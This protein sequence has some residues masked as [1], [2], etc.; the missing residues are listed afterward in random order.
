MPDRQ[1]KCDWHIYGPTTEAMCPCPHGYGGP[2]EVDEE[3]LRRAEA[4]LVDRA[5]PGYSIRYTKPVIAPSVITRSDAAFH[6][7]SMPRWA[8]RYHLIIEKN[9]SGET[10]A[11]LVNVRRL[12]SL[13]KSLRARISAE[14]AEKITKDTPTIA[15]AL[16]RFPPDKYEEW[17]ASDGEFRLIE[18]DVATEYGALRFPHAVPYVQP[19]E[20]AGGVCAHGAIFM[21]TVLL[22]RLGV[23]VLGLADIAAKLRKHQVW[24]GLTP[25]EVLDYFRHKVGRLNAFHEW[26]RL[27]APRFMR[28][29]TTALCGYL[30][31]GFPAII[32]VDAAKLGVLDEEQINELRKVG[33]HPESK[34][35][36]HVVLAIGFHRNPRE[37]WNPTVLFQDTLSGPFGEISLKQLVDA[38]LAPLEF[39]FVVPVPKQVGLALKGSFELL[40]P[41]APQPRLGVPALLD[42]V[43]GILRLHPADD[44]RFPR[45]GVGGVA[46]EDCT[47]SLIS[48]RDFIERYVSCNDGDQ[49]IGWCA[50]GG[51]QGDLP[52]WLWAQ[53]WWD[54]G[55]LRGVWGWDATR[56]DKDK[57]AEPVPAQPAITLGCTDNGTE[58]IQV[59]LGGHDVG[60]PNP[61]V[62]RQGKSLATTAHPMARVSLISSYAPTHPLDSILPACTRHA[63]RAVDL[64]CFTHW[65]L[66]TL[67]KLLYPRDTGDVMSVEA[68]VERWLRDNACAKVAQMISQIVPRSNGFPV[69]A[70]PAL[71][72]YLPGITHE[73]N[74]LRDT[75]IN[76]LKGL[77]RIG[78]EL[79]KELGEAGPVVLEIVAGNVVR[80]KRYRSG[81][82]GAKRTTLV[83]HSEL[84]K[85]QLL[86]KSLLNVADLARQAG[87]TVAIE[88]EPGALGVLRKKESIDPLVCALNAEGEALSF[89]GLNLDIG[90][91][92]LAEIGPNHVLEDER[93]LGRVCHAH[94]SDFGAGHLADLCPLTVQGRKVFEQWLAVLQEAAAI[95]DDYRKAN[96]LPPW[97]G[98]V[99]VEVEA[100]RSP[101]QAFAAYHRT[102]SL[103]RQYG[104]SC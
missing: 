69:L 39:D 75:S 13:R 81:S 86:I 44:S 90:H 102:E 65:Q 19:H 15:E 97:S 50:V 6:D 63:V 11:G 55:S 30:R 58:S 91:Y 92:C 17:A 29:V 103:I 1:L 78:G 66:L 68:E 28:D 9:G 67:H 46:L 18:A 48:A 51:L 73:Q 34:V 42:R 5:Y 54:E 70:I 53:E 45:F 31:S 100:C 23:A 71:A 52:N 47:Y 82:S 21:T 3:S 85:R 24:L 104:Y 99:A 35:L 16:L 10:Y 26:F 25:P 96:N 7:V 4:L 80:G 83:R 64:Y 72:S 40:N 95:P 8:Y 98:Y 41:P 32:Y 43:L 94:I 88:L 89:V 22:R 12:L 101:E 60:Y 76:G 49:R 36:A 33:P 57:D 74:N 14:D 56:K 77:L 38:R 27:P 62:M 93:I 87:L 84:A 2:P 20:Q 59:D 61:L 37:P 79:R